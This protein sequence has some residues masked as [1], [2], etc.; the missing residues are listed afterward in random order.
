MKVLNLADLWALINQKE[1]GAI[2]KR[3]SIIPA[4]WNM[5]K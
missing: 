1:N 4:E 5:S 3:L 2:F